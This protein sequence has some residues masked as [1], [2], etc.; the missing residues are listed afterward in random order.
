MFNK[1][2]IAEEVEVEEIVVSECNLILFS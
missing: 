2:V 1:S